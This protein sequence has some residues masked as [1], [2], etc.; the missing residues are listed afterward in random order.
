MEDGFDVDLAGA[1]GTLP[2]G[3]LRHRRLDRVRHRVC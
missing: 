2:L 3:G 1:L